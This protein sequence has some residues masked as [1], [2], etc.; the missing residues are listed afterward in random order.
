MVGNLRFYILISIR[1][2]LKV[3]QGERRYD[4]TWSQSLLKSCHF[5]GK[6]L[7]TGIYSPWVRIGCRN[8]AYFTYVL[9]SFQFN[10]TERSTEM[11]LMEWAEQIVEE[12]RKV[13][14]EAISIL[15]SVLEENPNLMTREQ[16]SN[17]TQEI[18]ETEIALK[19]LE[20]L[21]IYASNVQNFFDKLAQS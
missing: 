12:T 4:L 10:H 17:L 2:T 19:E 21:L 3:S 6:Y 15:K 7:S 13:G 16:I 8:Q 1:Y 5:L 14:I 18:T 11:D 9:T 20:D